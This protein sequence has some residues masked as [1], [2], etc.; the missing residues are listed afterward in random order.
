MVGDVSPTIHVDRVSGQVEARWVV[1]VQSATFDEYLKVATRDAIARSTAAEVGEVERA[2]NVGGFMSEVHPL[3]EGS[4]AATKGGLL[5]SLGGTYEVE[6]ARVERGAQ[7][8]QCVVLQPKSLVRRVVARVSSVG[9][10]EVHEEASVLQTG[11]VKGDRRRV[12]EKKIV[13]NDG[14]MEHH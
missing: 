6:G 7:V 2:V 3:A 5:G 1:V 10:V 13:M 8:G 11:R 4:V 9:N 14:D 12:V